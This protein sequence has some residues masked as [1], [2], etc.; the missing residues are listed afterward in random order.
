MIKRSLL[1]A[2]AGVLTLGARTLRGRLGRA[3]ALFLAVLIAATGFTV[4]TVS[5]RAS[6][7]GV[8]GTVN[9]RGQ[10]AYDIL[11]RP[12][13]ARTQ[14]EQA[15]SLIQGGYLSGVAGG[16][17]LGQWHKIEQIPGISVAAPI[18]LLGYVVPTVHV[19]VDLSGVAPTRGDSV[20]RMD[21]TWHYDNG[22]SKVR[23]VPD[24][25]FETD[26][27]LWPTSG[28]KFTLHYGGPHAPTLIGP[29]GAPV[30]MRGLTEA[31]RPSTMADCSSTHNAF[32]L[33]TC[34]KHAGRV[35]P[36]ISVTFPVLLVAVDPKTEA[37]LTG[38]GSH[39]KSGSGLGG[40]SLKSPNTATGT[41]TPV[42][43]ADHPSTKLRAEVRL[44]RVGGGAVQKVLHGRDAPAM[45]KLPH[46]YVKTVTVTSADAYRLLLRQLRRL[47]DNPQTARFGTNA[48]PQRFTISTPTYQQDQGVVVPKVVPNQLG[49]NILDKGFHTSVPASMGDVAVRKATSI[50][51][52]EDQG[53]PRPSTIKVVGTL[54]ADAATKLTDTTSKILSGLQPAP[55]SGADA[56]SRRLLGDRP[57]AASPDVAGLVQPA[58]LMITSLAAVDQWYHGWAPAAGTGTMSPPSKP[59]SAVRVKVAGVTG[60][61]PV[62]RARVKLAAQRIQQRTGLQVDITLGSS[63]THVNVVD[64]AGKN[65]RPKLVLAQQWVK[66]GV[67]TVILT[68]LDRKSLAIFCLVLLVCGLTVANAVIASVR[69]R[70]TE[71]GVL[72]CL[73]WAPRQIATLVLG[74]IVMVAGLAGIIAVGLSV[75]F[76]RLV[77]TPV[78]PARAALAIP[79]ALVV[80][81]AAGMGPVW[82]AGRAEPMAAVRES[83]RAPRRAPTVR[84]VMAFS[85]VNLTR[86]S[87]R[88]VLGAAGLMVAVAA[89]TFL[90]V[91]TLG[92]KGAVV[93]TVLGDAV[94]VQVRGADYAA[95][96]ATLLLALLGVAN[97]M[98]LNIR[99]RGHEL[100]T[101]AALGWSRASLNR[102]L[103]GEA[104]GMGLGGTLAGVALGLV[105]SSFFLTGVSATAMLATALVCTGIGILVTLIAA[106]GTGQLVGR[107]PIAILLTEE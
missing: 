99:E 89:S 53:I 50:Q 97:V 83:A 6:Q 63:A 73:G 96:G 101:L 74:E 31:S 90:V 13:G 76:G 85:R 43:A 71:F 34:V 92:F 104:L 93:G 12:K 29:A 69:A 25:A 102:A 59:I 39:V 79:A 81:L 91:I 19:P 105:G 62:S 28:G 64:P 65:G 24:F 98:Y 72:A 86:N 58:P 36:A 9:A 18:A 5:S 51:G 48:M 82:W 61:D 46:T 107:L 35:D 1:G 42:L 3:A 16:I 10:L 88:T 60:V 66:K 55:A 26:K 57:L 8:T 4:L 54:G 52:P 14:V 23:S 84:S 45:L 7:L 38:L 15:R 17:S 77:G 22:L 78:G 40:R 30:D 37:K 33:D 49:K 47:P 11:V 75:V 68:A 80:A 44:S 21:T 106:A 95:V 100:A 94:A 2:R 103:L 27:G 67:A 87:I 41:Y 56:R 32:N 20:T 70:R